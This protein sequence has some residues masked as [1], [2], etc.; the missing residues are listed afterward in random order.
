[1][2]NFFSLVIIVILFTFT[3]NVYANIDNLSNMSAEWIRTGNRNA[4]TDAADIVIYNPGGITRLPD[5]F[6]VNIG[7]QTLFRKPRHSYDLSQ[8]GGTTESHEQ[9]STDLFLPNVYMTYNK[10][11]WALFGGYYIPGG[12]AVV[13]YPD[14]SI[15]TDLIGLGLV[16]NGFFDA[17]TNEHLKGESVYNT[18]TFGGAYQIN[19]SV[20]LALGIRYIMVKNDIKVGL[21]GLTDLGNGTYFPT[22]LQVDINEKDNGVGFIAGAD[23][24]ITPKINFA[25]QYQSKVNLNLKTEVNRDDLNV[26]TDGKKNRRD[27]PGMLGLGLGYHISDALYSEINYSYWFQKN[28]NWGKDVNGRDIS[29]MAGDAQTAGITM[30]Y[31][32]TPHLLASM[33][34][35][36]TGFRWNDINEY[37]EANLG[38]YEVL[39]TNNWYF[40]CGLSWTLVD[41]VVM[42][43]S[44]GKTIWDNKDLTNS[45]L[46]GV[47]IHTE[48]DSTVGA[49]GFNV[50]F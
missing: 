16:N 28:C 3:N 34:T 24:A 35:T 36:Y 45:Q 19:N 14:G 8:Y 42:N 15:S 26:F 17:Y 37:Y 43:M 13:D 10:D 21:T 29:H 33:G 31:R 49:I 6:H 18:L 4:A 48:N 27:L 9:D 7:N 30:S 20:S 39:Y 41:N 12:G 5:G 47:T 46:P 32:F 38:S 22:E 1:M 25:V 40:G 11:K 44:L 50:N 2:R 23:I